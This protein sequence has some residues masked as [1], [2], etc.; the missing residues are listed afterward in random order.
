MSYSYQSE[1]KKEKKR[2][3]KTFLSNYDK[4]SPVCNWIKPGNS[5]LPDPCKKGTGLI[6]VPDP[7]HSLNGPVPGFSPET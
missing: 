7:V 4:Y 3:K 2:R 5:S 6:L 1:A